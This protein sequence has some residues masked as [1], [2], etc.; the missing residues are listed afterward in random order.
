MGTKIEYSMDT[1]EDYTWHLDQGGS[2]AKGDSKNG[3][4]LIST[5]VFYPIY[6]NDYLH[7]QGAGPDAKT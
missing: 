3:S 4:G 6:I 2:L 1:A 5:P 7:S